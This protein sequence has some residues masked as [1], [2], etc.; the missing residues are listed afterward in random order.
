MPKRAASLAS[1]AILIALA[2]ST[3][4]LAQSVFPEGCTVFIAGR[5]TTVDGSI[6]FVKT[7]DDG[8]RDIDYLWYIPRKT[9]EPGA[10]VELRAG[11]SI[12]QV[13]ETYAY[14]WDE[15]P[16][17]A[18]SNGIV[19]E[20]GVAF[21]SNACGSKEG[22]LEE[23][24]ARGD[25]VDGGIG[26]R[27]RMVL[28][29]RA[30]TA[31]EAVMI[32][33]QL[34]DTYGYTGSGRNLNIVGPDEAWQ[35]QM[36]RGKQYVARRVQDY[37]VVIIANTFS[38]RE[39][40]PDDHENFICSPRLI[41]YAIQRGWYDPASG[42]EFDFASVYAPER[43]HRSPSNTNRQWDLARLL[44]KDFPVTWQEAQTGIMPVSVKP[45]RKLSL[46]DV[47]SIIRSHYEG[48]ALDQSGFTDTG[49]YVNTP[50]R[51]SSTIC[52]YGSHRTTVV[53]QRNWLPVKIGTVT[54]RALDQPCSSVF[55]PWYLGVT[56][57]PEAFHKAPESLYTTNRDLLDYHFNA[58]PETWQPDMESA[59][60]IF[61]H[62]ADLVDAHYAS[63]IDLVQRRWSEYENLQFE[64]QPF[65][66]NTARELYE[67]DV[68]LVEKFLT[69][70][71]YS[72]AMRSLEVAH[73]LIDVIGWHLPGIGEL[74]KI[75]IMNIMSEQGGN[76]CIHGWGPKVFSLRFSSQ[77]DSIGKGNSKE[78]SRLCE[79]ACTHIPCFYSVFY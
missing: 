60:G 40:D 4:L 59:S 62:L 1:I 71:T 41:E 47:F 33:A 56:G 19:N 20:W 52:N 44:N 39:V 7:E 50:H 37:E 57:I 69:T 29:E 53:Q 12:P 10:V 27:L 15:C 79:G 67:Q 28:A 78:P 48:T 64:L 17:T 23:V 76:G 2:T 18:F 49:E 26:F 75:Q 65:I 42:K 77:L 70:Y 31:R 32:A 61:G 14:F 25:L 73:E 54:W 45:D 9:Y 46:G 5:N 6:L 24:A 22:S 55:V 68:D 30:R 34:L 11:G 58:P 16:G 43:R 13:R 35:L 8:P 74:Y 21:G 36:V 72:Q 3:T 38:I 51:T 63:T 66:E